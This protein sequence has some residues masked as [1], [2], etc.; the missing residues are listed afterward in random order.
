MLGILKNYYI[1]SSERH[2]LRSSLNDRIKYFSIGRYMSVVF[3][4]Q[5]FF[6]IRFS[7]F[8]VSKS[9]CGIS[10]RFVLR[11][12]LGIEQRFMYFSPAVSFIVVLKPKRYRVYYSLEAKRFGFF[13]SR[14]TPRRK[15][16]YIAHG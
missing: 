12:R 11:N 9:F 6:K 4:S 2:I 8:C 5:G 16:F 13:V 7:G 3:S 10:S 14:I 15:K 1:V